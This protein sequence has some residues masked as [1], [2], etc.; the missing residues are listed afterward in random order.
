MYKKEQPE[1]VV[2]CPPCTEFSRLRAMNRH[3]HGQAYCD[4]HDRKKAE[5]VKH[6]EFSIKT[7]KMQIRRR[8]W[9][10]FEHPAHGDTWHEPC[11]KEL[12][13]I[14]GVEWKVADQCQYGLLTKAAAGLEY[15]AQKPT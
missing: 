6:V 13:K 4:E 10:I 2:L 5:V 11:M 9:F 8:K 12:L 7:A 14:P 1:V 15:P 3:I